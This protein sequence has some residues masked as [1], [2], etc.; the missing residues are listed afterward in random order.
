MTP[1]CESDPVHRSKPRAGVVRGVN[2][3]GDFDAPLPVCVVTVVETGQ[4][5]TTSDRGHP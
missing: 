1:Q 5:V 2:V 4:R 3:D